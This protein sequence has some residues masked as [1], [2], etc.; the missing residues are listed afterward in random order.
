V[1]A[2]PDLFEQRAG[3]QPAGRQP[4]SGT[5]LFEIKSELDRWKALAAMY[6]NPDQF[7][8][9]E[10]SMLRAPQRHVVLGD[11]QHRGRFDEAFENAPQSLREVEETTGFKV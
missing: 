3:G 7:V 10:P 9:N 8:Y 1:M 4:A 6:A 5:T 2:I 11:A